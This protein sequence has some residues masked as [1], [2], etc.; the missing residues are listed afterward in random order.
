MHDHAKRLVLQGYLTKT[1]DSVYTITPAGLTYMRDY[2]RSV[3]EMLI[4]AE[5]PVGVFSHQTT[6]A[7]PL[8]LVAE[9]DFTRQRRAR[10][11]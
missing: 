9:P 7:I 10:A 5:A 6:P 11:A 3:V 8:Q 2:L 4:A 1:D